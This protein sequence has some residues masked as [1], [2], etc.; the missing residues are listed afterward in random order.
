MSL[1]QVIEALP[2][3]PGHVILQF[4]RRGDLADAQF[5]YGEVARRML[6]RLQYIRLKPAAILDAGCGAGDNLPLLR[7]RYPEARYLGLDAC[8]P[9]LN[10]S[11]IHI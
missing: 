3:V 8:A 9:L 11:L 5:L 2:I 6:G 4:A 7:E 10:L 1:S